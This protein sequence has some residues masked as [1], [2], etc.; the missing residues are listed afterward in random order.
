MSFTTTELQ[1]PARL[2]P[3]DRD[4]GQCSIL[5]ENNQ[6]LSSMTI[7]RDKTTSDFDFAR[8]FRRVAAQLMTEGSCMTK[9]LVGRDVLRLQP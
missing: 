4:R 6:L 9:P 8:V 1:K 2:A 7:L 3:I 5:Q